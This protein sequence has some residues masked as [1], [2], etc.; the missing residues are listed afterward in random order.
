MEITE[1]E[2]EEIAKSVKQGYTTGILDSE[3]KDNNS[4]RVSWEITTNKFINN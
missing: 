4:I 3:D 2:L 1:L